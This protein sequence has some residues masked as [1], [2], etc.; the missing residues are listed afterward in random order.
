VYYKLACPPNF[1]G[2]GS[3][4]SS[5]WVW[6]SQGDNVV[7]DKNDFSANVKNNKNTSFAWGIMA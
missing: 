5:F 1:G 6:V 2:Y 3:N 4:G 7:I